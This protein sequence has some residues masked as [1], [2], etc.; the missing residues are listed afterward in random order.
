MAT[1]KIL[2]LIMLLWRLLRKCHW[3]KINVNNLALGDFLRFE[4]DKAEE[5]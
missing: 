2:S 3:S 5:L 4:D 1:N